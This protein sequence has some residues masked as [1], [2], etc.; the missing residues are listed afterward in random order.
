MDL[1]IENAIY[2]ILSGFY[3]IDIDDTRYKILVP[4][5]DILYQA[6][7]LYLSIIDELKFDHCWYPQTT[8]DNLLLLHNIWNKSKEDELKSLKKILD[9]AKIQLFLKYSLPKLRKDNKNLIKQTKDIINKLYEQKN[10]FSCLSLIDYANSVKNQ[11]IIIHTVYKDD[12]LFFKEDW[13]TIDSILLDKILYEIHRNF[14]GVE[15]IKRIAGHPLWRSYWDAANEG[16]FGKHAAELTEEQRLLITFSKNYDNIK[17]HPECPPQ[18]IMD[19]MDALDGWMLY[20]HDKIEKE[21]KKKDIEERFGLN[22]KKDK[23]GTQEIFIPVSSREEAEEIHSLN[24]PI[25]EKDRKN[26]MEFIK[27]GEQVDWTNLPHVQ[28]EI[29]QQQLQMSK[30]KG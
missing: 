20:Q 7:R 11:F 28:R 9:G 6:H 16:V 29:K 8:I 5:R 25:A 3:Y 19:D 24:D 4:P 18:D 30:N 17:E 22:N 1:D 13:T 27:D 2:R 21:K 23:G 12:Q 26:M 14:I 10:Y 15:D